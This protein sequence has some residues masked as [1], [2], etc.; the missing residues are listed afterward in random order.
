MDRRGR[1]EIWWLVK[2]EEID[3][4]SVTGRSSRKTLSDAISHLEKEK[5]E[6]ELHKRGKLEKPIAK[7]RSKFERQ[8]IFCQSI[9]NVNLLC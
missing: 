3:N 2:Q 4:R 1:Q 7:T 9:K 6:D 5:E 8:K